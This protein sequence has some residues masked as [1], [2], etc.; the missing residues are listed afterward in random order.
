MNMNYLLAGTVG[1]NPILFVGAILLILAWKTAG[2]WG[3]DRWALLALG[4]PWRPGW[5]F[6]EGSAPGGERMAYGHGQV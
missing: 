6:H 2:W 5:I 1:I 4:T 3:L